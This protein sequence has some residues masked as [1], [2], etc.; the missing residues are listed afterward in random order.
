MIWTFWAT[1]EIWYKLR[2]K[3]KENKLNCPLLT[4]K[5]FSFSLIL[6]KFMA[7]FIKFYQVNYLHSLHDLIQ[8]QASIGIRKSMK[9]VQV[10][11]SKKK[12]SIKLIITLQVTLVWEEWLKLHL[13][14]P[15]QLQKVLSAQYS[16]Q[17]TGIGKLT[18][19]GHHQ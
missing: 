7:A 8:Q 18:Q 17:I 14:Y 12:E 15:K 9:N 1:W 3:I 10:L 11:S 2:N 4:S 6:K 19:T 13:K 16:L 5:I